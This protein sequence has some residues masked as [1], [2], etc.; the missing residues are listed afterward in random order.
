MPESRNERE[1]FSPSDRLAWREWLLKNS[2]NSD[3]V[4]VIIQ[5]KNSNIP[6]ISYEEAVEEAVA[7]GW[8]DSKTKT[9]DA[10][11]FK[12][13]FT[14]RKPG[15]IWS[16]SNKNRIEKLQQKGLLTEKARIQ[17]EEAKKD[18]SWNKLNKVDQIQI[19]E[20]FEKILC[21]NE[22]AK[23][24]FEAY[25]DS[26]KKQILWWIESAKR[27]ETRK[28]RIKSAVIMAEE[29]RKNMTASN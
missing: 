13:V 4:W 12:Q 7:F 27:E 29:N 21:L 14:P 11:S 19:P 25:S 24:N 15:S 10:K 18:G 23:K 1:I 6:G 9:V 3:G 8:I 5:K 17:I 16:K 2:D 20:D 28:K 22:T 26:W